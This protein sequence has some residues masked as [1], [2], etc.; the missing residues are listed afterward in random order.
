M[1]MSEF[2]ISYLR[3]GWSVIPLH[4]VRDGVCSCGN[5]ECATPGKHP[6][7]R[8]SEFQSRRPKEREVL[9]WFTRLFPN[10]N[11]GMVTGTISGISV[12][13][14][15]GPVGIESLGKLKLPDNTLKVR[16]GGGGLHL[17]YSTGKQLIQTKI[18]ALPKLDVKAEKGYVVLP[19]SLHK[20]GKRYNW[21][22]HLPPLS[23]NLATV[24]PK[25]TIDVASNRSGWYDELLDGVDEGSRS[26]D[27]ARLAGRYFT[28]GLSVKETTMIMSVWNIRNRPP[29]SRKDLFNTIR[30][31]HERHVQN[32]STR[33]IR[34]VN[35]IFKFI[36]ET[37]GRINGK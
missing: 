10:S 11:I 13:D 14:C 31:V 23:Y 35:E 21:I 2:A 17:Y 3:R 16:S 7:I 36:V 26:I 12:I 32:M 28:L 24:L 22:N 29:L 20:S 19:P 9:E 34:S 30:S 15:D 1:K 25:P 37:N 4:I 33:E 6:R 27:A 5:V 8:W 18:G